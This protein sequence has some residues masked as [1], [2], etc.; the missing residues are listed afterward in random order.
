LWGTRYVLRRDVRFW[1]KIT[2][3]KERIRGMS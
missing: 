2:F 3:P 1:E